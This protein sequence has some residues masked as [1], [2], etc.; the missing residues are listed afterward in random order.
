MTG[1]GLRKRRTHLFV[2]VP[3]NTIRDKSISFRSRG[4][5]AYLLDMP[6]GWDVKS[7]FLATQGT[8]GREAVRTAVNE[9]AAA[10]YYRLER[11]QLK[12]GTFCMGTSISETPVESWIADF[13]EFGKR[14]VPCIEQ[15][16]GSFKVRHKDGTLTDDGFEDAAVDVT[17]GGPDDDG[18]GSSTGDGFSG[19]GSPGFGSPD[20]GF[21]GSL[22]D[23]YTGDG[24]EQPSSSEPLRDS[25]A[26]SV[27]QPEPKAEKGDHLSAGREDVDRV[28]AHLIERLV[29]NECKA[30]TVAG[31]GWRKAARLMMDADGRT[32]QQVHNMI[33][34]ATNDSFW[35]AN[36]LSMPTLREKYD[37]MRL[38]ALE[39]AT[40]KKGG[41]APAYSDK[42][43]DDRPGGEDLTDEEAD[44]VFGVAPQQQQRHAG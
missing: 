29:A 23:N 31:A 20:S 34:W 14:G 16:N 37:Q 12:D 13:A 25:D 27:K 40:G 17:P 32:E 6:D 44:R 36:I 41:R 9:L 28:C 24:K 21:S 22:R 7:E 10:G 35:R 30:P 4:I 15:P 19:F 42:V 3:S 2:Q 11:R 26:E 33:E 39:E 5:L 18:P 1:A 38:R 8:E 43:W